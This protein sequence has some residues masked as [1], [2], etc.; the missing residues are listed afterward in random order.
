MRSKLFVPGSR[1]E[2]FPKAMASAADAIS[3]DLE[4]AVAADRKAEARDAVAAFLAARGP[5]D[6]KRVI[7][8]VNA[9]GTPHFA[10]D[11]AAVLRPGLDMV[12]V[13]MVQSPDDV[14]VAAEVIGRS[15][16]PV[17]ILAN[18]E[19]PRGLR[20][21][22]EI[23]MADRR[24]AGLQ[25][26]FGDLF[27]P[28]GIDRAEPAA[29][30]FVL[31]Q[32][33]LA[34]AEAGIPAYDGAFAGVGEPERFRA[35]CVFARRLGFAGKSCIHPSQ[36]AIANESFLPDKAAVAQARRVVEAAD[37]AAAAG[38]GAFLVDGQMVD[39][40]F[41]VSARELVAAADRVGKPPR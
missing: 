6:G 5:G 10:A 14:R 24:V 11:M 8:R 32:L 16:L 17:T 25:V 39:G 3:F 7:V 29:L 40:P 4:D 33:R 1:P 15:G 9:P 26:G 20:L 34:A 35:E 36:V 12:N 21:A 2:L 28:F 31:M 41:I 19:T 18:I 22:A 13:P 27:E 30:H 23:A 37:A 38:V